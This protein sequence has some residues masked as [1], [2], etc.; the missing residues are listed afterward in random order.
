MIV[1][2]GVEGTHSLYKFVASFIRAYV[3]ITR[4]TT[5]I[6]SDDEIRDK[7]GRIF[8]LGMSLLFYIFHRMV[9]ICRKLL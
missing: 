6:R 2:A 3:V 1:E 4:G 5:D 9:L 7:G 8:F